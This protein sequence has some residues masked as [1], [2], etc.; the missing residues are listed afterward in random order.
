MDQTETRDRPRVREHYAWWRGVQVTDAT[1]TAD[2][3]T[4][5]VE[6]LRR[7]REHPG[8]PQPVRRAVLGVAVAQAAVVAF[9]LAGLV[10]LNGA[11][12]T[13]YVVAV[14]QAFTTTVLVVVALVRWP[15]PVQLWALYRG[16][17]VMLHED[18]DPIEFGK[19]RRAV[20]R[21]MHTHR[22]LK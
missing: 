14:A 16:E 6:D 11:G 2:G 5:A 7:L 13:V 17:P 12:A 4:F 20:E 1:V 19:V 21:A 22:L 8:R 15:T 18:P 10:Y 3:R 9:A